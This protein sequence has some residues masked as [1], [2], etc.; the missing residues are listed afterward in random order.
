VV[1]IA[2]DDYATP[3]GSSVLGIRNVVVLPAPFGPGK[4]KLGVLE[5]AT[6][7]VESVMR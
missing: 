7:H 1:V 2:C 6:T 3:I 5:I 4:P